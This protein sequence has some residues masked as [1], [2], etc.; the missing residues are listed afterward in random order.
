QIAEFLVEV[1]HVTQWTRR[2]RTLILIQHRHVRIITH[3]VLKG[4]EHR[5]IAWLVYHL[6]FSLKLWS[7][8]ELRRRHG[9]T[10]KYVLEACLSIR[11][12]RATCKLDRIQNL[13]VDFLL[14]LIGFFFGENAVRD[15]LAAE[16]GDRIFGDPG[17]HLG[18]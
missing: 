17:P 16:L 7:G 2:D 12:S 6:T 11:C 8:D 14:D 1:E 4:F 18:V 9:G 3:A 13:L 10:S 5:E 15:Q